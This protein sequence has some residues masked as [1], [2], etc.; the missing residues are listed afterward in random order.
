LAFVGDVGEADENGGKQHAM[1]RH[2]NLETHLHA[3]I[4]GAGLADDPKALLF[5][6]Y[7]RATGQRAGNP[8]PRANAYMIIQRRSNLPA[9]SRAWTTIRF[10]RRADD[11]ECYAGLSRRCLAGSAPP[12]GNL[13]GPMP[14]FSGSPSSASAPFADF[15]SR[16]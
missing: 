11:D 1:P 9:S 8:L 6:T 7:S 12:S 10:G 13:C 14:R 3:Y 4:D 15:Y 16:E 5:Q 2:H